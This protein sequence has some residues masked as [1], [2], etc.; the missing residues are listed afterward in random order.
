MMPEWSTDF[1]IPLTDGTREALQVWVRLAEAHRTIVEP[2]LDLRPEATGIDAGAD[3]TPPRRLSRRLRRAM[4]GVASAEVAFGHGSRCA[5]VLDRALTPIR[6]L[7][8]EATRIARSGP[9]EK[10]LERILDGIADTSAT[11]SADIRG[12]SEQIA[13][14]LGRLGEQAAQARTAAEAAGAKARE[15]EEGARRQR[16]SRVA[17]L[18]RE[19]W[20]ASLKSERLAAQLRVTAHAREKALARVRLEE[21]EFE[22]TRRDWHSRMLD[23]AAGLPTQAETDSLCL[24]SEHVI[25]AFQRGR[26]ANVSDGLAAVAAAFDGFDGLPK[27]GTGLD[28]QLAGKLGKTTL[29]EL[30]RFVHRQLQV[31][32]AAWASYFL[33]RYGFV[34]AALPVLTKLA[35]DVLMHKLVIPWQEDQQG[36]R[37]RKANLVRLLVAE[38][39]CL[40]AVGALAMASVQ[41]ADVVDRASIRAARLAEFAVDA[42]RRLQAT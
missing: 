20:E 27:T 5:D 23:L 6:R 33:A 19:W 28:A 10:R 14:D 22:L 15:A 9:K 38:Q 31:S 34:A 24:E 35:V 3:G 16:K 4:V 36:R 17:R 21:A 18:E 41:H 32:T 26:L 42:Q 30:A 8:D 29:A 13:L 1:G 39:V 11:T 25:L 37:Q 12:I 7:A 40:K 2:H